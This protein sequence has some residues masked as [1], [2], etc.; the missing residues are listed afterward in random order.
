M[1]KFIFLLALFACSEEIVAPASAQPY[2]DKDKPCAYCGLWS[3]SN[4]FPSASITSGTYNIQLSIPNE[5]SRPWDDGFIVTIWNTGNSTITVTASGAFNGNGIHELK[6]NGGVTIGEVFYSR[7]PNE[8][9]YPCY[10]AASPS[11][12]I[13]L[14]ISNTGGPGSLTVSVLGSSMSC[15]A[16]LSSRQWDLTIN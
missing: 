11:M 16:T 1:N 7:P 4:T 9:Q 10:A 13:R 5:Y 14:N 15:N 12:D 6:P 2:Y 3:I 8:K